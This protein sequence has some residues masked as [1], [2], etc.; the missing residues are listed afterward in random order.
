MI[1]GFSIFKVATKKNEKS[2][3]YDISINIG[4]KEQPQYV[5]VGGGWVKEGQKGKFIS[6]TFSKAYGDRKEY[7][8]TEVVDPNV[9][10]FDRDSQGKEI[11]VDSIPF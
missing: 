4:T 11:D 8:I 2:P 7:G 5:T 10:K 9:P 1:N 6:C 3:D